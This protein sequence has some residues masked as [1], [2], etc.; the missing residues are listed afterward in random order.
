MGA[1]LRAWGLGRDCLINGCR[2]KG[3]GLGPRLPHKWMHKI[4]H[5][6]YICTTMDLLWENIGDCVSVRQLAR[7]DPTKLV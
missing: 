3:L 7:L 4:I 2:I 5:G 6:M 1:G